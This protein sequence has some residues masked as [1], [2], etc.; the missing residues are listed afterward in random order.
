MSDF[1]FV[2]RNIHND[3]Q[4]PWAD[5]D[6]EKGDFK[7]SDFLESAINQSIGDYAPANTDEIDRFNG[8]QLLKARNRGWYGSSYADGEYGSKLWL[9]EH[10][11]KTDGTLKIAKQYVEESLQWIINDGIASE[12]NVSTSWYLDILVINIEVVR[13]HDENIIKQYSYVWEETTELIPENT[14]WKR[15]SDN[16]IIGSFG[17]KYRPIDDLG[18]V[19]YK[20]ILTKAYNSGLTF[21]RETNPNFV[22]QC[23]DEETPWPP[24][25]EAHLVGMALR[26]FDGSNCASVEVID[27]NWN[28]KQYG[29]Y[30]Y[31]GAIVG[32]KYRLYVDD[33]TQSGIYL[34]P[35]VTIQQGS[36]KVD[37]DRLITSDFLNTVGLVVQVSGYCI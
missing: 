30:G 37:I 8:D 16:V 29:D 18:Y 24:T 23:N 1:S 9:L 19:C 31:Y 14:L 15:F 32:N 10:E 27:D 36:V 5:M 6:I 33:G 3:I 7:Q 4:Y 26:D 13:E 21:R 22:R 11:K 12:I 34:N 28:R 25:A 20:G 35:F 2:Q 17:P